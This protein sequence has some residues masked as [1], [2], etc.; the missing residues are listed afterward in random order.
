MPAKKKRRKKKKGIMKNTLKIGFT[1]MFMLLAL[2]IIYTVMVIA[3][4]SMESLDIDSFKMSYSGQIYYKNAKTGEFENLDNVYSKENRVW[5][6]IDEMPEH[7]K[8]AAVAIEDE[9]FYTHK[10]V[11]LKRTFGAVF[12]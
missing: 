4:A 2:F 10:G 11:D 12:H 5:V 1:V 8:D 9:R 6:P 3:S 7:L